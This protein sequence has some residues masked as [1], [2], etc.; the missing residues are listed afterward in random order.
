MAIY[1]GYVGVQFASEWAYAGFL[2]GAFALAWLIDQGYAWYIG[3]DEP[4]PLLEEG[5]VCSSSGSC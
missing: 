3:S 4:P 2:L 5:D 1:W